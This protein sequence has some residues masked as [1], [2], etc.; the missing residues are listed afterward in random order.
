MPDLRIWSRATRQRSLSL[1]TSL[2]FLLATASLFS[3]TIVASVILAVRLPQIEARSRAQALRTAHEANRLID[4]Q[5]QGIEEQLGGLAQAL[6]RPR[7]A[8]DV[9]LLIDA[10]VGSGLTFNSIALIDRRGRLALLAQPAGA[11]G[12]GPPGTEIGHDLSRDPLITA[13]L[14][15]APGVDSNALTW[16]DAHPGWLGKPAAL[17]V[18]MHAGSW[19]LVAEVARDHVLARAGLDGY[20]DDALVM[21]VDATGQPLTGP[22]TN[23]LLPADPLGARPRP[24]ALKPDALKPDASGVV[25]P[26]R[27]QLRGADY[28]VG[29]EASTRLGWIALAWMPTG[30]NQINYRITVIMVGLGYVCA[31]A[32]SLALAPVWARR[33]SRPFRVIAHNAHLIAAGKAPVVPMDVG[34]VQEFQQLAQDLERMV[35]ALRAREAEVVRS[36]ARL[37]SSLEFTPL[38]AIQWYDLQ[39]RILYWNSASSVLYGFTAE[40]ALGTSICEQPLMFGELSRARDYVALLG[41]IARKREPFGPAEFG[42]YHRDGHAVRVLATTFA[43]ESDDETPILVC[44]DID[45]TVRQRME[46][47][48]RDLNARLE[49]R[50]AS[51]TDELRQANEHLALTLRDLQQTQDHL[52]ESAKL[53]ALGN[54][55]AGVA[56]ELNTPIGN[57]LM[58]VSTLDERLRDFRQISREGLRYSDLQRFTDAVASACAISLRNLERAASLLSSFKQVAVDQTSS[59][60]RRF[61][62]REVVDEVLLTL[63]PTLRRNRVDIVNQVD[64]GLMLDSYPGA[65]GQVLTN[66]VSNAVVHAFE[67]GQGGVVTIRAHA[68]SDDSVKLTVS[69]N[70]AGIKPGLEQRIFEPFFTTRMGRGGSGLGLHI[71]FNAVTRVLGGQV[72]V[73]RVQPHGLCVEMRAPFAAPSHEPDPARAISSVRPAS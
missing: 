11:S 31:L 61:D 33:L 17:V 68:E 27:L 8:D 66:L 10:V 16:R 12:G 60:R 73:R 56:H 71:V 28:I 45:I 29:G 69:D 43:I 47:E 63:E 58:A 4:A 35:Q 2:V 30:M 54:L 62:L 20:A 21:V 53:A 42:L 19:L 72:A 6:R 65:W 34:P 18:A 67:P 26:S 44:M 40:Q 38:V 25:G 32:L 51:R 13:L 41:D 46:E 14:N 15:S 9:Q 37:K 39:G 64:E 59:Q 55:V 7:H 48:L 70:G 1:R 23:A 57:G 3:F 52:I 49:E 36:E 22:V 24:D 50:V 5:L